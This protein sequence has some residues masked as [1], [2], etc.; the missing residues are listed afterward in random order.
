MPKELCRQIKDRAKRKRCEQ[1]QGEFANLESQA[2]KK[3][4]GEG[5]AGWKETIDALIAQKLESAK[6][7][8]KAPSRNPKKNKKNKSKK[9]RY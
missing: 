2:R 9:P 4:M 7:S 1:Y 5:A 8:K 6:R 3:M